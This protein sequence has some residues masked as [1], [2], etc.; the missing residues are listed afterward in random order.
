M[1]RFEIF[2]SEIILFNINDHMSSNEVGSLPPPVAMF[3]EVC[4]VLKCKCF[5]VY[6]NYAGDNMVW[7]CLLGSLTEFSNEMNCTY[8]RHIDPISGTFFLFPEP[9][10]FLCHYPHLTSL[11]LIC[12]VAKVLKT[13]KHRWGKCIS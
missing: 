2:W 5:N 10:M 4:F 3:T 1:I 13:G 9:H 11:S 7:N 12:L 6:V 8:C